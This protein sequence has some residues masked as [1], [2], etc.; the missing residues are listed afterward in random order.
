MIIKAQLSQDPFHPTRIDIIM[1]FELLA[2]KSTKVATEV[3]FEN[4]IGWAY[5]LGWIIPLVE[6]HLF[7][8]TCSK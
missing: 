4:L 5:G 6:V 7:T 2:T 1:I 8:E 3:C